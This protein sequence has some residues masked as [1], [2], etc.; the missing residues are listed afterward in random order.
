MNDEEKDSGVAVIEGDFIVIRVAISALEGA[1]RENTIDEDF[2]GYRV[3]DATGFAR[4]VVRSL[5]EESADGL[6][7]I[8]EL[9][10]RAIVDAVDQG[11]EH[12][13]DTR[14]GDDD[15]NGVTFE[16]WSQR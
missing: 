5:N 16:E 15:P 11:S 9:I 3:T 12:V 10:D 2:D 8:R 13:E 4:D 7:P 6:M 1:M 14:E